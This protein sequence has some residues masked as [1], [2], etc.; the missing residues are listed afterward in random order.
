MLGLCH[1]PGD[2]WGLYV[3]NDKNRLEDS[4]IDGFG[5]ETDRQTTAAVQARPAGALSNRAEIS[6]CPRSQWGKRCHRRYRFSDFESSVRH[7]TS[8]KRLYGL[9]EVMHFPYLPLEGRA[10]K[11]RTL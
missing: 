7:T 4:M 11:G 10:P 9:G 5:S 8:T 6:Q 3:R 2:P 1:C